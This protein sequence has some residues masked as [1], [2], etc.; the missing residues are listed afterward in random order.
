CASLPAAAQDSLPEAQAIR[1]ILS[2]GAP[3]V[4][5]I[6]AALGAEALAAVKQVYA[7]RD[8]RPI[9]FTTAAAPAA[10]A[11]LDRLGQPDM[12]IGANVKPL[13]D[14]ARARIA[15]PNDP[16]RAGA[17]LLLTALYG[18]TA[19]TLRPKDAPI[20]FTAALDELTKAT[21]LTALLHEPEAPKV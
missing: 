14:A 7:A 11:L 9:W 13:L 2:A 19:R 10:H 4:T 15:A 20:G 16:A 18:A 8:D 6:D 21:N 3:P 5:D 12:T 1:D 17:D